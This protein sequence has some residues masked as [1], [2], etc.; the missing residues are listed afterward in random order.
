VLVYV[1]KKTKKLKGSPDVV[2]RGFIYMHE[3]DEITKQIGKMASEAYKKITQ[4]DPKAG[5]SDI[6][7]YIKQTVDQYTR[8]TL[9]RKPLVIPLIVN[10]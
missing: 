7:I 1:D 4:K 3:S 2:S 6:K 8:K 10:A 9:E 5:R